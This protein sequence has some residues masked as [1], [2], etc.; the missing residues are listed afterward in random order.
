MQP[1][2]RTASRQ[3]AEADGSVP[4]GVGWGGRVQQPQCCCCAAKVPCL[5]WCVIYLSVALCC[6]FGCIDSP[7]LL[8]VQQRQQ[9]RIALSGF[10][11]MLALNQG[12]CR[13]SAERAG[14]S[15]RLGMYS[16]VWRICVPDVLRCCLACVWAPRAP[17]FCTLRCDCSVAGAL[18]D[19]AAV[20]C[21]QRQVGGGLL[22]QIQ[23]WQALAVVLRSRWHLW[24]SL[25]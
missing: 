14:L 19:A 20:C 7:Y 17:G 15:C 16:P 8:V 24:M 1:A 10:V 4:L 25:S 2:C 23:A 13:C 6:L 9:R 21:M 22:A 5:L 18:F 3:Q 12:L 11:S